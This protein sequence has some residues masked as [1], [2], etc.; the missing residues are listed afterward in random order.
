M[1]S[2]MFQDLPAFDPLVIEEKYG[3]ARHVWAEDMEE[4]L[5]AIGVL[6]G[7]GLQVRLRYIGK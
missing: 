6:K 7:L 3:W 5:K 1:S 4:A 2:S